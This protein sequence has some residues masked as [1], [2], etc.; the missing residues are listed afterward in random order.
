[1]QIYFFRKVSDQTCG[2]E[3]AMYDETNNRCQCGTAEGCAA[4]VSTSP[5]CDAKNNICKCSKDVN[6]CEYARESCKNGE[7]RCGTGEGCNPT[8]PYC[9]LVKNKCTS[10]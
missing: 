10:K 8:T 6:S 9:D 3:G 2:I 4:S 1:M 7:C 5:Y